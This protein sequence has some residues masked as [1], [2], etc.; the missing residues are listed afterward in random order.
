[1]PAP[2]LAIRGV[3][4]VATGQTAWLTYKVAAPALPPCQGRGQAAPGCR[5]ETETG[6]LVESQQVSQMHGG[7]TPPA[8]ILHG[9]PLP[10]APGSRSVPKALPD[11]SCF[12]PPWISSC[13]ALLSVWF[14]SGLSPCGL[15]CH[16]PTASLSLPPLTGTREGRGKWQVSYRR[17]CAQAPGDQ[18]VPHIRR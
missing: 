2:G 9:S 13:P 15:G 5:P 1:M 3:F 16:Q 12:R 10:R 14:H 8:C 17:F 6:L 11:G 7:H 4:S 18:P